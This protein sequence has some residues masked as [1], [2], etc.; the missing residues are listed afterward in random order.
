MGLVCLQGGAEFR[1]GCEKLDAEMLAAAPVPPGATSPRVVIVPFASTPGPDRQAAGRNAVTWYRELGAKDLM[2]L[3]DEQPGEFQAGDPN[4]LQ[5]L[6]A[7]ISRADLLVLP[8]GSPARLLSAL[9]PHRD[10]LA[11]LLARGTAISGASAGAMVLCRWT[12]LPEHGWRVEPALGLVDV[13]LVVPHYSADHPVPHSWLT[14]ARGALPAGSVALGLPER[15]GVILDETGAR[16]S[17][18]TARTV[19]LPLSELEQ[20][21]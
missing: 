5:A 11:A 20:R 2:V 3:D 15:S 7:A 17:V 19:E 4:P 10:L 18:G 1:P 16:R 14:A 8:G 9:R 21:R 13:D 12:V 6:A